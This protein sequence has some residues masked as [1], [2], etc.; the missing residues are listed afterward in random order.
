[1]TP[2]LPA[3]KL[4]ANGPKVTRGHFAVPKIINQ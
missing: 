2:S 1:V 4:L 3:E